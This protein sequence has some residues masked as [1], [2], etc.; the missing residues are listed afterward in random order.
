MSTLSLMLPTP[1]AV[2][3]APTDA[4]QVQL[5]LL[6]SAGKLSATV[7]PVTSDGP[8]FCTVIV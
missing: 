2:H 3:E 7:A 8:R 5:M 1:A 4:A 6:N